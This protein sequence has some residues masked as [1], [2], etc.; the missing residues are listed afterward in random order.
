MSSLSLSA[1]GLTAAPPPVA[2][3]GEIITAKFPLR[4][5]APYSTV[6]QALQAAGFDP[7]QARVLCDRSAFIRATHA[8]AAGR[9]VRNVEETADRLRFQF[10]REWLD[11]QANR[12][13]YD[14]EAVVTLD[15]STGR[16]SCPDAQLE[17]LAMQEASRQVGVRRIAD[18]RRLLA[19]LIDANGDN[20]PFAD[21]VRFVPVQYVGFLDRLEQ[22]V[23][24]LGGELQRVVVPA[25]S[26]ITTTTIEKVIVDGVCEAIDNYEAAI[27]E[28]NENYGKLTSRA[29]KTAYQRVQAAYDLIW[30][31][32]NT[33]GAHATIL[34]DQ[35]AYVAA[36][37][38]RAEER[39]QKAAP[40]LA[41]FVS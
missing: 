11:A 27:R 29:I 34:E 13:A 7:K 17:A 8:L 12:L 30:R 24:G 6:L 19:R 32:K 4:F 28:V 35:V 39:E 25:G 31:Y 38:K 10:T 37:L 15:K 40:G 1:Q 5:E 18:V 22:L 9:L 41:L 14:F 21:G 23:R 3:L 20:F 33:L 2:S 26:H 16:I 36:E